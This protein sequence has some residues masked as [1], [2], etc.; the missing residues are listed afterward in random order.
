MEEKRKI[1]RS[2]IDELGD[3][4]EAEAFE[5]GQM[6]V[7]WTTEDYGRLTLKAFPKD[8]GQ[9]SYFLYQDGELKDNWS[10]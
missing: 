4:N 3:P 7:T 5:D 8:S 10:E 2:L 1:D 6:A 9:H